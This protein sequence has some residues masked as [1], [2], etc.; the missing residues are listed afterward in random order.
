M[1]S[2]RGP[3]NTMPAACIRQWEQLHLPKRLSK[4]LNAMRLTGCSELCTLTE[5][6]VARMHRLGTC[7]PSRLRGNNSGPAGLGRYLQFRGQLPMWEHLWAPLHLV[8]LGACGAS[9]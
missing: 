7:L 8:L 9:L 4:A 6:A 3:M 5:E 1:V 2:G